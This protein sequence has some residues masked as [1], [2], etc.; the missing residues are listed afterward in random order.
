MKFVYLLTGGILQ[1]GNCQISVSIAKD[2]IS[3]S[4]LCRGVSIMMVLS[5]KN[6][7][8]FITTS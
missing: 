4:D 6:C 5:L 8:F 2:D 3:E 7:I 1:I